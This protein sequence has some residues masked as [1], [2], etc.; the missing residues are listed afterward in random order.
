[1]VGHDPTNL[2]RFPLRFSVSFL[3]LYKCNKRY[4]VD[5]L[6]WETERSILRG[7]TT[8]D[9]CRMRIWDVG[10]AAVSEAT[11]HCSCGRC[12][13]VGRR[14]NGII[15]PR[16]RKCCCFVKVNMAKLQLGGIRASAWVREDILACNEK[17]GTRFSR[18]PCNKAIPL[19]AF[20]NL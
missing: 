1:M 14:E 8:P 4:V 5:V 18:V 11:R 16:K 19:S 10:T 3:N 2:I 9:R 7:V 6:R 13:I 20:E 12:R 15:L 17:E